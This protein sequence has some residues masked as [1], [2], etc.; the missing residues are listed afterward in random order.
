[1]PLATICSPSSHFKRGGVLASSDEDTA[2]KAAPK[3]LGWPSPVPYPYVSR[4]TGR[5]VANFCYQAIARFDPDDECNRNF[6]TSE[7]LPQQAQSQDNTS[8]R[9]R[10]KCEEHNHIP[11]LT[12]AFPDRGHRHNY[13]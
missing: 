8:Q 2:A 6:C 12:F 11:D 5:P 9:V 13:R 10:R 7:G 1:M 4:N 3:F